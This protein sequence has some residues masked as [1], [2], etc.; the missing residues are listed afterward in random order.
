MSDLIFAEKRQDTYTSGTWIA[1]IV[2]DDPGI[3]AITRT[4]LRD[5]IYE[6][7]TLEFLSAYSRKEAES[8]FYFPN[9]LKQDFSVKY[10]PG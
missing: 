8:E 7:R 4:V 10:L 9:L 3:H 1:L 5:L 6:N 2:D